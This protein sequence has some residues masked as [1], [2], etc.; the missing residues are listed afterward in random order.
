MVVRIFNRLDGFSKTEELYFKKLTREQFY[1]LVRRE[2]HLAL[3]RKIDV[4]N[5]D[6][7]TPSYLENNRITM[8][9]KDFKWTKKRKKLYIY[10]EER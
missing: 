5:A 6:E 1:N 3:P 2:W 10:Y 9:P 8:Y 7:I 4:F